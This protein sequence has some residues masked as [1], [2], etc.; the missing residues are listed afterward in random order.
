MAAG[1][2]VKSITITVLDSEYTL[3]IHETNA[4]SVR[5]LNVIQF[6]FLR[7]IFYSR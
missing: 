2:K 1:E 7:E 3:F 4:Y 6:K 5:I